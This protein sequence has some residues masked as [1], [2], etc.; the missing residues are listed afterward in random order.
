MDCIGGIIMT[1][2]TGE[3]EHDHIWAV[4]N[5]EQI[6]DGYVEVTYECSICR[7]EVFDIDY[8]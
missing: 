7:K 3:N 4:V 2:Y 1:E 8:A 6:S 5:T